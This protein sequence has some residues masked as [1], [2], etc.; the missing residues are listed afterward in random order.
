MDLW[1][2]IG[3]RRAQY[4]HAGDEARVRLTRYWEMAHPLGET[5]PDQAVALLAE[6]RLLAAE[7]GERWW[8]LVLD[9]WHL[10][11]LLHFKRDYRQ[12]AE[13]AVRIAVAASR[14][15]NAAFPGR[16]VVYRDLVSAY[17]G[18]DPEGYA[19]RIREALAYL[20]RAIPPEPNEARYLM[21]GSARQFHQEMGDFDAA[22][23]TAMQA[24]ALLDRDREYRHHGRYSMIFHYSALCWI[25]ARREDWRRL[26][27]V[28]ALGEE[29]ARSRNKQM[30]LCEFLAWQA[31][32]ARRDGDESRARRLHSTA[33]AKM[34]RLRMPSE[35]EYP[36]ATV[37]FHELGGELDK[38]LPVRDRELA[39]LADHGRFAY[40]CEAHLKRA[41]LRAKMGLLRREDLDA[42]RQ[43]ALKLRKP[44]KALTE[45]ERWLAALRP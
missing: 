8:Q 43:A 18:V 33:A 25:A 28:A 14:P 19:D 41:A 11:A 39:V 24:Q 44:D 2:W 15:E 36:D 34:A 13:A 29:T 16:W 3:E 32:L 17:V 6:G 31:V 30:E 9:H 4:E 23:A 37:L 5:D 12:A 10:A 22:E 38:A 42:A 45:I 7:L 1:E 35:R 20:D 27:E 21:L 40:E 26:A